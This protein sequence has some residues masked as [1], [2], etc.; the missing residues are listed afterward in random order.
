MAFEYKVY[1]RDNGKW[2]LIGGLVTLDH[3]LW[4]GL[5]YQNQFRPENKPEIKIHQGKRKIKEF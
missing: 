4:F 1:T 5:Y 3:A 2:C